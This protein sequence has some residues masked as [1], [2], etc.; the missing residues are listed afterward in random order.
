MGLASNCGYP[1]GYFNDLSLRSDEDLEIERNDVRDLLR[2]LVGPPFFSPDKIPQ[3]L[4][5]L[6]ILLRMLTECE[7]SVRSSLDSRALFA[8]VVV[9]AFS[10][11]GKYYTIIIRT[12]PRSRSIVTF[13]VSF[14]QAIGSVGRVPS[15]Y[16]VDSNPTGTLFGR[17]CRGNVQCMLDRSLPPR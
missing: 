14:S 5:P 12:C 11:L 7:H 10:A 4:V 13:A 2:A 8:E 15:T 1:E 3:H 17:F 16:G 6:K 9:H